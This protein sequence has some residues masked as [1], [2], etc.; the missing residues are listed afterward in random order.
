MTEAPPSIYTALAAVMA[1]VSH[2]AKRDFNEH[3][4]FNF[5]GI[6]AVVNAVGPALR[7]HQVIVVPRV[8]HTSFEKVT[9][10]AGRPSTACRVQ[11]AYV[12]HGP[13]GD[14]IE[15]VVIGEAWDTGDKAAPKAMSVAF[16]TAL[17]QALALPTDERDPDHAVY[18]RGESD[19]AQITQT[20][21]NTI[22]ALMKRVGLD[23]EPA[24]L[25]AASEAAGRPITSPWQM[26][27]DDAAALE[28]NLKTRLHALQ[29]QDAAENG[30]PA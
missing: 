5:R 16:R 3:H 1:D 24:Q 15:T 26:T 29:Q 20:Q 27:I 17:L 8:E 14:S 22:G 6:D 10:S 23:T 11:V 13:A 7:A 30:D 18:E 28:Q 19:D 9:T 4:R 21:M 2:V 12:F 25:E